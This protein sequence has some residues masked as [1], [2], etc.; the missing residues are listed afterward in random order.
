MRK[1]SSTTA[2]DAG[3]GFC[4]EKELEM[5]E[6]AQDTTSSI[7]VMPYTLRMAEFVPP[8][9]MIRWSGA[10]AEFAKKIVR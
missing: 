10:V 6:S 8:C 5:R 7:Q 1:W 2:F 4:A 3:C 9:G